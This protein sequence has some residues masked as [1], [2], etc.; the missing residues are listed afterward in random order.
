VLDPADYFYR[1]LAAS[2]RRLLLQIHALAG[3]YGWTEAEILALS[4]PR[5]A[6]YVKLIE[7]QGGSSPGLGHAL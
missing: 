3:A 1:E 7:E 4:P 6:T 2:S 5:R